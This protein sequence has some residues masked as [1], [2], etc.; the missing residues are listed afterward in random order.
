M[1]SSLVCEI[2]THTHTYNIYTTE[3]QGRGV[4]DGGIKRKKKEKRKQRKEA[5]EFIGEIKPKRKN[6]TKQQQ[7]LSV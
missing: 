2:H 7:Q 5:I 4:G 6:I 1:K 3:Q